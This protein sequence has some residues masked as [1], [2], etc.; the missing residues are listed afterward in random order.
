MSVVYEKLND[1]FKSTSK[2][3]FRQEIGELKEFEPYLKGL[4][5][6]SS[7]RKS[8]ISGKEVITAPDYPED[9][10]IVSQDEIGQLEFAPLDVN[11]IKDIDSLLEAVSEN[12]IYCGNRRFGKNSGVEK[13]DNIMDC[14]NVF[15]ANNL[16]TS[17]NCAYMSFS[18]SDEHCF[19]VFGYPDAKFCMRSSWGM[20][21]TRCFEVYYT[22]Y[23]SDCFFCY[24]CAATNDAMFSFNLRGKRYAIGNLELPK[25]RYLAIKEKLVGE[26]AQELEKKK[27]FVSLIDMPKVYGGVKDGKVEYNEPEERKAEK[28]RKIDASFRTA[29]KLVLGKELGPITDYADWLLEDNVEI[30]VVMGALGSE[31]YKT[32]FV[33]G[34]KDLPVERLVNGEEAVELGRERKISIAEGEVPGV[35]E[36]MKRAS[37]IAYFTQEMKMGENKDTFDTP[38]LYSSTDTYRVFDSTECKHVGCLFGVGMGSYCFGGRCRLLTSKFCFKCYN[39]GDLSNCFEV[40][41][42]YSSTGCLF[43]HNVENVDEGIF[44]FNVKGKR[45]AVGNTEVGREEFLRVKKI[46]LDYVVGELEEKK[47][48]ELGI[49]NIRK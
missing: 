49:F 2:I 1:A 8:Y 23:S 13:A 47:K 25:E 7:V 33:A 37:E 43:C 35:A 14:L 38:I 22:N 17:K 28:A 12:A 21:I 5:F 24:N 32:N 31:T 30:K 4:L 27:K 3:L 26:I 34:Y 46:L 20:G 6:P 36:I 9:A 44:C 16:Y 41:G 19:G 15:D 18:R 39:S 40:D 42:S 10:R 29:T 45:Y 11:R 48:C